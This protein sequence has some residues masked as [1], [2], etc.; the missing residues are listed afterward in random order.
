MTRYS[1]LLVATIAWGVLA[2]GAV[3]PWAYWPLAISSGGLGAWAIIKTGAWADRRLRPLAIVLGLTGLAIGVQLVPLPYGVVMSISPGVDAFLREFLL[4]YQRPTALALSID[5]GFT[6]AAWSLYV[7]FA[8]LLFGLTRA[9]RYIRLDWLVTQLLGLGVALAV[10]GVL[11]KAFID[12]VRPLVYG[13]WEPLYGGNPFGPFVNR[14]HFAGWM[15]MALPVV[16]GY[17]IA[18]FLASERPRAASWR[19]WMHWTVTVEANRFLLVVFAVMVMGMSVVLTGSRSGVAAFAVAL[20]AM[21]YF[22]VARAGS[23]G[24]RLRVIA[25]LSGMLVVA[26]LW[27]GLGET[28]G[29]FAKSSGD[30][31]GRFAAWRD[32]WRIV[33]DFPIFGT[34]LGTYGQS[35]LIYQTSGR[36]AFYLQ[37]HNDYIQLAAEGGLLVLLPAVAVLAVMIRAISRRVASGDDDL[38]TA[39]IRGGAVAGLL[40]IATQSLVE[41]SL[42]MPG[43][44][45]MFVL[46]SAIAMHHPSRSARARRV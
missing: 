42:Q 8:A 16:A 39:W 2:F 27:A 1:W 46:L 36:E 18:V 5:P 19:I 26:V 3:Y 25:G 13:F 38:E 40:G 11:Q 22:I 7:A 45:I 21:G 14:N 31:E 44:T 32:A 12:P 4:G 20:M 29:R 28:I 30:L 10:V 37:A 35:M 41:F 34:G 15:V 9:M 23:A 6:A 43:N 24:R 33:Q 17:G